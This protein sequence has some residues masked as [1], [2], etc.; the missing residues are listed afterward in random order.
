MACFFINTRLRED[1]CNESIS[2][3]SLGISTGFILACCFKYFS[4]PIIT[5]EHFSWVRPQNIYKL[6]AHFKLTPEESISVLV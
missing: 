5:P 6:T 1:C 3:M 4:L 2:P